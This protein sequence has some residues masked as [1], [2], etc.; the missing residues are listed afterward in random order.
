MTRLAV[1]RWPRQPLRPAVLQ[2]GSRQLR[3]SW[4]LGPRDLRAL[5][6]GGWYDHVAGRLLLL[7]RCGPRLLL[8]VGAAG[9]ELDLATVESEWV[10]AGRT[11]VL[12]H[13]LGFGRASVWRLRR[14]GA[15]VFE[16]AYRRESWDV[17]CDDTPFRDPE[18]DDD[19][20]LFLHRLV[21]DPAHRAHVWAYLADAA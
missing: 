12:L 17:P 13:R 2:A 18:V 15:V 7:Y 10:D 3:V 6:F 1:Y 16:L 11:P 19:F 8:R 14:A 20:V 9:T 21:G 5:A 4:G